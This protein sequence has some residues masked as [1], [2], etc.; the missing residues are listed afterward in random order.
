MP[1]DPEALRN[2]ASQMHAYGQVGERRNFEVD[3]VTDDQGPGRD[4]SAGRAV[5]GQRAVG[6]GDDLSP[7]TSQRD[8][9]RADREL[10]RPVRIGQAH[11]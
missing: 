8:V 6:L 2:V 10:P 4:R 3:R 11:A 1:G 5:E 9:R 7:F